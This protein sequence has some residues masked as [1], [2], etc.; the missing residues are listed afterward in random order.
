MSAEGAGKGRAVGIERAG[1]R[2]D[3]TAPIC[4][5]NIKR[6]ICLKKSVCFPKDAKHPPKSFE[7]LGAFS[8]APKVFQWESTFGLETYYRDKM[9]IPFPKDAEHPPESFEGLG[10]FLKA[11]KV[12]APGLFGPAPS[13]AA[14]FFLPDAQRFW[15]QTLG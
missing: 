12:F 15:I 7:G 14:E 9:H 5:I 8:K 11:P 13:K 2:R 1:Q 10:A 6:I 4:G 3:G